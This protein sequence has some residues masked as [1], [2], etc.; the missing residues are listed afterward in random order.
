MKNLAVRSK[1]WKILTVSCKKILSVKKFTHDYQ[2]SKSFLKS[3]NFFK[4]AKLIP[5]ISDAHK[6]NQ[7]AIGRKKPKYLPLTVAGTSLLRP[8]PWAHISPI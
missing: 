7:V 8:S 6:E 1:I 4:Q 5:K 2:K 3:F